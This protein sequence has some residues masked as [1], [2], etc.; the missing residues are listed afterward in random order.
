MDMKGHNYSYVFNFEQ[1]FISQEYSTLFTYFIQD[2]EHSVVRI[3][4]EENWRSVCAWASGIYMLLIFGGQSYMT[5]RYSNVFPL[6]LTYN[7]L[8]TDL[9]LTSED[10]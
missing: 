9:H 5:N 3:W 1:V 10:L 4:M 7:E 6:K 2:F 8:Y